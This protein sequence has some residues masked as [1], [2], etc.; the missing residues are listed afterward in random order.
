ML[1]ALELQKGSACRSPLP[2]EFALCCQR[3]V[4]L[5]AEWITQLCAP[6]VL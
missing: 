6:T 5:V 2:A 1:V 3:H 4:M